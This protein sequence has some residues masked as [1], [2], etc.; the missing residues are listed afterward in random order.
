VEG[1]AEHR[2]KFLTDEEHASQSE[3]AICCS[4]AKTNSIT[5]D[6]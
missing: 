5:I 6:F 2:D 3:I 1:E 4:R